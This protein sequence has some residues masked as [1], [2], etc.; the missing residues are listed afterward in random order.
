[1]KLNCT[2]SSMHE[3][4]KNKLSADCHLELAYWF[5]KCKCKDGVDLRVKF[6]FTRL[7]SQLM[8]SLYES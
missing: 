4:R 6:V 2:I 5:T 7:S 3:I 1:M 8:F